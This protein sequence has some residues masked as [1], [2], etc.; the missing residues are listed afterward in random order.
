MKAPGADRG[1]FS[2]CFFKPGLFRHIPEPPVLSETGIMGNFFSPNSIHS[3]QP[4]FALPFLFVVPILLVLLESAPARGEAAA[5]DTIDLTF[6]TVGRVEKYVDTNDT[7]DKKLM[8]FV[9]GTL[10]SGETASVTV[11][12]CGTCTYF[13]GLMDDSAKQGKLARILGDQGLRVFASI[14]SIEDGE[15]GADLT[16]DAAPADDFDFNY[17][18]TIESTSIAALASCG[19]VDP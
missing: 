16:E 6:T 9:S 5:V 4:I 14:A 10:D 3:R 11:T 12:A 8:L 15:T 1:F 2:S 13:T 18:V 7:T 17:T 19:L